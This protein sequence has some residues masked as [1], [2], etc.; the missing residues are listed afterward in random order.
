VRCGGA[1]ACVIACFEQTRRTFRSI[2][3]YCFS[4]GGRVVIDKKLPLLVES[5]ASTPP[6]ESMDRNDVP[7]APFPIPRPRYPFLFRS[8]PL[9]SRRDLLCGHVARPRLSLFR[10]LD[11]DMT[12][13]TIACTSQSRNFRR[14][15]SGAVVVLG[16]TKSCKGTAIA[17]NEVHPTIEPLS[18]L[19]KE[20]TN[21]SDH[22][23]SRLEHHKAKGST[24][25]VIAGLLRSFFDCCVP[26]TS[27]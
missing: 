9:A 19:N 4:S 23:R 20:E 14:F 3:R 8:F 27:S 16:E 10:Q 13:F 2:L 17:M 12:S 6:G 7:N 18:T 11:K 25:I 26:G 15:K 1:A 24:P 21:T 22:F 5:A